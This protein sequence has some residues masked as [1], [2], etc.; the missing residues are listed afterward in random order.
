MNESHELVNSNDVIGLF[1]PV[2]RTFVGVTPQTLSKIVNGTDIEREALRW[3]LLKLLSSVYERA[4]RLCVYF[5][6]SLSA[7]LAPRSSHSQP[8]I[9]WRDATRSHPGPDARCA[10]TFALGAVRKDFQGEWEP[11]EQLKRAFDL[12][13]TSLFTHEPLRASLERT[14]VRKLWLLQRQLANK[15]H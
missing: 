7:H 5:I 14:Q 3:K 12:R 15:L 1:W 2:L 10:H 4:L 13:A 6:A 8:N 9:T 11:A